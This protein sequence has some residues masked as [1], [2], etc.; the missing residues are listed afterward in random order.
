[1]LGSL[2]LSLAS[3]AAAFAA[4][5]SLTAALS[6]RKQLFALPKLSL[7]GRLSTTRAN[8]VTAERRQRSSSSICLASFVT[9]ILLPLSS[10]S[11]LLVN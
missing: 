4:L 11:S 9:L 1:M 7:E 3:A 6:R 5:R 8:C 2:T 10:S